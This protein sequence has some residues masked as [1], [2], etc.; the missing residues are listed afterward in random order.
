MPSELMVSNLDAKEA[1]GF[2]L[3]KA[4]I[5]SL[6]TLTDFNSFFF[7]KNRSKLVCDI[8]VKL[9]GIKISLFEY[10]FLILKE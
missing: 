8:K 4:A 5:R 2:L 1:D 10:A 6:P 3:K 7:Q 9:S